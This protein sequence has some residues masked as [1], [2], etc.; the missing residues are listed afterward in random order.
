MKITK[1]HIV[2]ICDRVME[3]SFY[4]LLVVV[5]FSNS[6]VEIAAVSMISAWVLKM[7]IERD[8][9]RLPKVP[10][11]FFLLFL[12]WVILSCFNSSYSKES[13]RG[14]FK[15]LEQGAVFFAASS[16]LRHKNIPGKAFFVLALGAILISVNGFYQ[17]F[18]GTDLIRH[19]VLQPDEAMRRIS[20][21]FVHPNDFGVYLMVVCVTLTSVVISRSA[22]ISG[23]AVAAVSLT[24]SSIALL[25]TRSR[26]AFLSAAAAFLSLGWLRSRKVLAAFAVI[27]VAIFVIM[28]AGMK[29][30]IVGVADIH[31]GT[32]WE[33]IQLWKGTI[34]MIKAHPVLG[35]GIN[36]YSRNFPD[37]KPADYTDVRYSH[38][39]YLHMAA[40]TGIPGG[41][42]F[43]GFILSAIVSASSRLKRL[44]QG[45]KRDLAA[46]IIAGMVGFALNSAVDTHLFSVTLSIFFYALLGYS[47]TLTDDE[48]KYRT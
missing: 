17:Y 40:E 13:F 6:L 46:G 21:S 3:Y 39:C 47:L 37:Y 24:I 19:R 8:L 42:L 1:T 30:S 36:T 29:K 48:K 22:K 14:V 9:G 43:A 10:T 20:S 45:F 41:V 15:V 16:E 12:G 28:P 26:G 27:L 2:A 33:R 7:V 5:A 34:E 11:V 35:F 23:R 25:M 32:T 18:S 38:N 31:E 44:G 4:T